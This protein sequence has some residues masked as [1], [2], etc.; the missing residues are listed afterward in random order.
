MSRRADREGIPRARYGDLPSWQG[1]HA[2]GLAHHFGVAVFRRL[3]MY[4]AH[5]AYMRD[6][7]AFRLR[8][9]EAPT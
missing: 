1:T 8:M 6:L 4:G 3:R 9:E 5:R 7:R 2:A